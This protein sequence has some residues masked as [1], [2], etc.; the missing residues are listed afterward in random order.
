M[1]GTATK[2]KQVTSETYGTVRDRNNGQP[3]EEQMNGLQQHG[4]ASCCVTNNVAY[5]TTSTVILNQGN[6]VT[7]LVTFAV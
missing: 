6:L 4:A 7:K 5:P 2:Q 3:F 1:D